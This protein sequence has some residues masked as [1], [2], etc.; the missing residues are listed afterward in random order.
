MRYIDHWTP[1]TLAE[2]KTLD[3]CLEGLWMHAC[4]RFPLDPS[5]CACSLGV[6]D[7]SK[8]AIAIVGALSI[9]RIVCVTLCLVYNLYTL[10]YDG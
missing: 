4:E 6:L 9:S 2:R 3:A 10:L 5:G 7:V 1:L 8:S